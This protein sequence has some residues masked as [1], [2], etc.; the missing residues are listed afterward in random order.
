MTIALLIAAGGQLARAQQ[1]RPAPVTAADSAK[2]EQ[3]QRILHLPQTIERARQAGVPDS[4]VR[5]VLRRTR[6]RG[7]PAED[8]QRAIEMETEAVER[9][10]KAGDFG[11]FVQS[12]ID[13]GLRGRD[14]SDAIRAEHARRG[15]GGPRG[16][17]ARPEAGAAERG[18]PVA[19][20]QPGRGKAVEAKPKPPTKPDS[21]KRGERRRGQ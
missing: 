4:Q 7:V 20:A 9:G 8:A 3:I 5:E 16:E 10:E 2:I 14:L 18:R 17:G 15:I 1:R 6:E 12:Q 21:T 13:A 19:G 11:K